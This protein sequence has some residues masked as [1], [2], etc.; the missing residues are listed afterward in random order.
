MREIKVR[1]YNKEKKKMVYWN[2]GM[3]DTGFWEIYGVFDYPIMLSTSLKDKNGKEIYEGDIVKWSDRFYG[4]TD[5]F[6]VKSLQEF[7]ED[8]G[9][10][11]GEWGEN[12]EEELE[13]IGNIYEN[14][15]LLKEVE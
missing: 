13:V 6:V 5:V 9:Y 1:A 2:S 12:W 3:G 4:D 14:P 8:K 10:R 15:E 11:E 7:F